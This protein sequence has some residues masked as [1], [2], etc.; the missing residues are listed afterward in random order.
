MFVCRLQLAIQCGG[1]EDVY[2][3]YQYYGPYHAGPR[4]YKVLSLLAPLA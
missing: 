2:N 3:A 1:D 4:K